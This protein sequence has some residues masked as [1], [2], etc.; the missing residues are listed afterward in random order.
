[1][2]SNT[3]NTTYLG[4]NLH[5]PLLVSASPLSQNIDNV[6]Q[7]EDAGAGAIVL[8]SL[9]EEQVR[10]D[11]QPKGLSNQHPGILRSSREIPLASENFHI[12]LDGYLA[13]I[14]ECKRAVGIPI[15]ASLN[16]TSLGT[17]TEF[18]QEIEKAGADA[19]EL[20]IHF[21]PTDVDMT[22]EQIEEMY[23]RILTSVKKA[24]P[25]IPV[26]V[27]LSPFFTNVMGMA[28]RLDRAGANGL[29]LFNRFYQPDFDPKT[30]RFL[31]RVRLSTSEDSR[32]PL[33]WIG[34][35]HRHVRADLG[36]TS[37]IHTADDVVKM[38]MVGAKVTMLASVLLIEGINYLQTMGHNLRD[39][40]DKNDYTSIVEL[41]GIA[42]Q[43]NSRDPS[44]FERVEYLRAISSF[45]ALSWD[46]SI[47]NEES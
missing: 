46:I 39:W 43:F 31:S 36:A 44:L 1:M 34:L 17:W 18:A 21:I 8:F 16:C 5:S 10:G 19:L 7:M 9:F 22:S 26:A 27:K 38:L 14:E 41:Q 3:L 12:D 23:E 24:V 32:L 20:H 4:M 47:A 40:L 13:H 42:S 15:I 11:K 2:N 6:R 30:L 45:K 37:G 25:T 33:H 35:L 28:R 29:V